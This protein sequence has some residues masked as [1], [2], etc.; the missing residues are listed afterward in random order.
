MD[1]ATIKIN[2]IEH[3]LAIFLEYRGG[4]AIEIKRQTSVIL[5]AARDPEAPGDLIANAAANGVALILRIR[6]MA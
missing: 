4:V 6:E 2:T 1:A 3:L 5:N